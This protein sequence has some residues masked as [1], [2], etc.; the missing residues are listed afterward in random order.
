MAG[1]SRVF[2]MDARKARCYAPAVARTLSI[3]E[4][5]QRLPAEFLKSLQE[6]FPQSVS[7][8]I[9]RGMCVR[10][11]TTL[12]VNTLRAAPHE[13][14]AFLRETGVKFRTV[15]WCP[16]GF[17]MSELRERDVEKWD[18]YREGRIYLQSLSSM[19]P[20]MALDPRPGERV[21][22][23]AAAPGS[24][25]TQMAAM[26]ENQGFIMAVELDAIRAERLSYNVAL[27]GCANVEVRTGRGERMGDEMPAFFDRVLLDVPC[28]GEGRFIV[29]LPATSRSWSR[30]LVAD[31]ARLQKKLL[32]SGFR[33][34]RPG[35]VLVYSTCTLNLEENERIIQWALE[36]FPLETEKIPL[37]IPGSWAGISR[38]QNTGISKALR[39]FPDAQKEGF[40]ICR[41]RKSEDAASQDEARGPRGR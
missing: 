10:R 21:L 35:G 22:D 26:M 20:V 39:L 15:P 2:A 34:L 4:A 29:G 28:S 25:T 33:A 30:K 8:A 41:M 38:G 36:S 12:R 11:P 19:V 7:Q 24:K 37:S 23:I 31:R 6:A 9:L 17:I 14:A 13:L 1:K 18:W 40:F 27:Q 16:Q 5:R 3:G 32:A